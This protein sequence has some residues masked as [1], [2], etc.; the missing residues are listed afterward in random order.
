MVLMTARATERWW[1]IRWVLAQVRGSATESG[2][3]MA[4]PTAKALAN[5]TEQSKVKRMARRSEGAKEQALVTTSAHA[6]ERG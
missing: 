1:E 4:M 2:L 6:W 3:P 5:A